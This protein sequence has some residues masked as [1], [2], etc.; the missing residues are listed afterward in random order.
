MGWGELDF[1][2]KEA[3]GGQRLLFETAVG[4]EGGTDSY[5][6]CLSHLLQG[7]PGLMGDTDEVP[8]SRGHGD[9]KVA[10]LPSD[11]IREPILAAGA[12]DCERRYTGR[13]TACAGW[14]GAVVL[15]QLGPSFPIHKQKRA[16]R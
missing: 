15:G 8:T 12:R 1:L 10:S 2:G 11:S 5:L 6:P 13:S 9:V 3:W 14:A 4:Q 16:S 7:H